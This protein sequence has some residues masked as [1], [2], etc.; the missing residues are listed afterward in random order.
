MSASVLEDA[1]TSARAESP[2]DPKLTSVVASAAAEHAFCAALLHLPD[3]PD[4]AQGIA[5]PDDLHDPKRAELVRTAFA[6][7]MAGEAIDESTVEA[8][9]VRRRMF[10]RLGGREWLRSFREPVPKIDAVPTLARS[11]AELAQARAVIDTARRIV[12]DGLNSTEA[13]KDFIE[14]SLRRMERV[15]E[16]RAE[17]RIE[18]MCDVVDRV[19]AK[20]ERARKEGGDEGGVPT[21]F[22]GLDAITRGMRLKQTSFVGALTGRGKSVYAMQVTNHV[23]GLVY[24][25]RVL[26]V[27]YVSGEMA[28][29]SL[30]SRAVCSRA[31]VSERTLQRVMAGSKNRRGETDLDPQYVDEIYQRVNQQQEQLRRAPIALYAKAAGLSD[32]RAACRDAN[33]RFRDL[34]RQPHWPAGVTPTVGLIV[35]DYVQMMKVDKKAERHDIALGEFAYGVKEICEDFDAHGLMPAQMN[36]N[37]RDRTNGAGAEDMKNA[38]ALGESASTAMNIARPAFDLPKNS[39]RRRILW[40]Y[41]IFQIT[42]GRDHDHADVAMLFDGAHYRFREPVG[43]EIDRLM[44]EAK[45]AGTKKFAPGS[46]LPGAPQ[47]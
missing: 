45:A 40:P 41:T 9:L 26:G 19:S 21:G 11:I 36:K 43:D 38:S 30:H 34:P 1:A 32:I 46:T 47:S 2:L 27:V 3:A 14:R 5:S 12:S 24:G 20:W 23:G 4:E 29:D 13:P 35:V 25:D 28:A 15:G 10:D 7:R 33:R 44:A 17:G 6:L 42:K 22:D 39:E 18:L 37:L 16:S 31:L 8:A